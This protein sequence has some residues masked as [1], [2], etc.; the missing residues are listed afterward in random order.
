MNEY[1]IYLFLNEIFVYICIYILYIIMYIKLKDFLQ[2][3]SIIFYNFE[4]IK[5]RSNNNI[6]NNLFSIYFIYYLSYFIIHE[7]RKFF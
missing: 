7:K 5:I 1:Q 4:T 6:Y 3:F 2:I